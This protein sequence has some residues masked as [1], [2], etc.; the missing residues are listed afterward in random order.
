MTKRRQWE[1]LIYEIME[2]IEE[3]SSSGAEY[4]AGIRAGGLRGYDH[5]GNDADEQHHSESETAGGVRTG[6]MSD[7]R[8]D[9]T[10]SF[11][12]ES[13]SAVLSGEYYKGNDGASGTGT[14]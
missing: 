7:G 4:D 2:T 6:R 1:T 11:R 5:G 14:M 8:G 3:D 9:W 12:Q 13:G 10:G